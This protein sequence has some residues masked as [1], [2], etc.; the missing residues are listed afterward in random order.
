MRTIQKPPIILHM[1]D[2]KNRILEICEPFKGTEQYSSIVEHM[3]LMV[4]S[5]PFK[6]DEVAYM[7]KKAEQYSEDPWMM[8]K[9][10]IL[11]KIKWLTLEE[12]GIR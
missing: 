6:E 3:Q 4:D 1:E 8:E 2:Y 7:A 12:Q 9:F 10:L 11:C 5:T